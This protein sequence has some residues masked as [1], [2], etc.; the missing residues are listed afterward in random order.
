MN[1]WAKNATKGLIEKVLPPDTID[2]K[3]VFILANALYFKGAWLNAFDAKLTRHKYFYPNDGEPIQV[4]FVNGDRGE[5][6]F[7]LKIPYHGGQDNRQFS[8]Y[9][10]LPNMK[11]GLQDLIQKFNST[12]KLL[13]NCF[14]LKEVY[15]S[16]MLIPKFKFSY[17]FEASEII[18]HLEL[19]LP[20]DKM[21]ADSKK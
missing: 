13:D 5:T 10:F 1:L 8:M 7:V 21:V 16:Q 6:F 14:K 15:L 19:T 20:F 4:P 2:H 3:T 12:P 11:D 9:V 18:K 17:E